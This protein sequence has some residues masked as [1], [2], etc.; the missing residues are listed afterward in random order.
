[1]ILNAY[2]IIQGMMNTKRRFI[3]ANWKTNIVSEKDAENLFLSI[4]NVINRLENTGMIVF[5]PHPYLNQVAKHATHKHYTVGA[6]DAYPDDSGSKTAETTVSMVKN[7]GAQYVILGH[8]D[9][10]HLESK[11]DVSRKVTAALEAEMKVIICI[12]EEE[13]DKNWKKEI[14]EQL[15]DVF[16]RVPKKSADQIIIAY[17]PVWAI[18]GDKKNPATAEQFNEAYEH[19]RKDLQKIFKTIK[20][21]EQ[22]EIIYGGSLDDKN[23]EE[24]LRH[25]EADGFLVSRVSQDPRILMT[26]FRLIEEQAKK[27]KEAAE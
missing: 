4:R 2:A 22:I 12:G 20:A 3:Y 26:M 23:I 17:E 18:Y 19:I 10:R 25:T 6:Q 24:Y 1:M 11:L 13:R 27:D 7:A 21:M 16:N 14:S 8:A 15:K 5:P 9:R